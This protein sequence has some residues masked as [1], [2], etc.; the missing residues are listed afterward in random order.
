MKVSWYYSLLF[1]LIINQIQ[2]LKIDEYIST[3]DSLLLDSHFVD[4]YRKWTLKLLEDPDYLYPKKPYQAFP[5]EIPQTTA[6]NEPTT[7][8]NLRPSDVQCVAAIGDSLTAAL[9]AY[10]TTPIGLFTENRGISWSI[11]GDYDYDSALTVPNILRKYNPNLKGYATKQSLIFGKGQN[12]SH[13]GLNAAESGDTA[14][15]ML[16]QANMIY[17]R[18]VKK[19]LCD[20][21]NDWKV[22]T[23]LIGGNDLCL[24]CNDLNAYSPQTYVKHIQDTLDYFHA[25]F[26]KTFVNLVLVLNVTHVKE[27]NAGGLVCSLLHKNTCPCAAYPKGNDSVILQQW[28]NDYKRLAVELVNSGRY[29]TRD[30]F[31]VVVQPFMANTPIPLDES[32]EIDY[33][34]FAPDCFHFSAKGH[35]RSALALWNN[36]LEPIGEKK[37]EW[38]PEEALECPTAE[39][40]YFATSK[41][42]PQSYENIPF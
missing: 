12:S 20:L 3:I 22:V 32:G 7:V 16:D 40:P 34:Y 35:S 37:W 18:I 2:S 13:N 33:S 23:L 21:Q 11:G 38:H 26:P 24:F 10:A 15:Y 30:D 19:G 39:R 6:R 1:I 9:G 4:E 28:L 29:D 17:Q 8:H 25:N 31:T 42:S 14:S 5:C 36:M 27:M 41:N